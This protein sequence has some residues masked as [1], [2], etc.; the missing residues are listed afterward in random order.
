MPYVIAASAL[1]FLSLIAD[2]FY[3]FAV[4]DRLLRAEYE[5]H[6]PE[7]ERDGR[8]AGFFWRAPECDFMTSAF[9]RTRLLFSWLFTTPDWIS[10]SPKLAALLRR[11]RLA[12]L[13]WNVGMLA[14]LA[15]LYF[16]CG[17]YHQKVG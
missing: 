16:G 9:A 17:A 5:L 7:W 15:F 3:S 11:Q 10:D 13:I 12:V 6:R 2:L 1:S 14:L 8:P 4:F